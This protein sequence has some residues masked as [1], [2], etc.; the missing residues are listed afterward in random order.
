MRLVTYMSP[1]FPATLFE[2]VGEAIGAEVHF[3]TETSGP[4]PGDD[5]FRDG[6]YDLG[7]ICS[8]SFVDLA[9]RSERPSVRLAGVGWVPDDPDAAGRPVYFGDLVV[10]ADSPARSLADL[11]GCRI[12]CNDAISL[13]G[14][15]A[16]RFAIDELGEQPVG[17]AELVFTGGHHA[18][19]DALVA[20]ELDACVVDSVVRTGRSCSDPAV[21]GL[22]ILERLGPWPVR[23]LVARADLGDEIVS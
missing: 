18:S 8:T 9:L 6:R 19:L 16:L 10:R 2:V 13:S 7:W 11:R 14:H 12:G 20:G 21:A 22:R 15:L 5:P 23:P 1:G 4:P 17:F 3:E